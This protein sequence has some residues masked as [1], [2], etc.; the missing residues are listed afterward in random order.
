MIQLLVGADNAANLLR[1][2]RMT[3]EAASKGAK[4][5]ALQV[6]DLNQHIVTV[7]MWACHD[8]AT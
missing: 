6:S 5:V 8:G 7:H 3:R 1:A 4:V 2:G